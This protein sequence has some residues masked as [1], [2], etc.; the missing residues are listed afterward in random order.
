ML[1]EKMRR[2][3]IDDRV[4]VK[5]VTSSFALRPIIT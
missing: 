5:P 4:D 2:S 1:F 3:R